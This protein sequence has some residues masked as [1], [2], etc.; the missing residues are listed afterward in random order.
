MDQFADIRPYNDSEVPAV[1]N[2]L[3]ADKELVATLANFKLGGWHKYVSWLIYPLIRFFL[4]REIKGVETVEGFQHV[5]KKY[6][7]GMIESTTASFTVSG[8]DKLDPAKPYLFMS[9]H[10]DITLDPAL[11]TYA[12][13]HNGHDTARIAIGD[14]LLSKPFV[15]DLMRINKSFLV[16]RSA[17]GARQ[18]L[19]AYKMLSAYIR[20][21]I[22]EDNNPIWIAQ[23][24]GRA[25]DGVD[26]T[27][28]AIIKMLA[29]SQQKKTE[30]FSDYINKLQIVP[31]SISYELDPC[32]AAK[33]KELYAVDSEGSY[34]KTEHEDASSIAKGIAGPKG[35]VHVSFGSPLRGE[36][37]NAEEVAVAIDQQVVNNYVLHP[38]NFFAYKM[39]N[40]CYPTGTY[41]AQHLPFNSEQ[42]VVAEKA[43]RER[44][45]A[46]PDEHRKYALGIYANV[47]DSKSVFLQAS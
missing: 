20:Y 9:N 14:N 22:E 28:P 34:Q 13:Y 36:F 45:E 5:M 4:R 1:L 32:D 11:I 8:L 15:S 26:R 37:K 24:E 2:R 33:A 38:T 23:R 47:F 42:L 21:S 27:Q 41:S 3:L 30:S 40:G 12:L 19:A 44:I 29:M 35:N 7:D 16:R 31:L 39:L 10:R 18:I 6:M 43:F 46:M 25:K 17:K